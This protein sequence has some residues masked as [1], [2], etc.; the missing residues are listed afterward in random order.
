MLLLVSRLA[1]LCLTNAFSFVWK[2]E[3]DVHMSDTKYTVRSAGENHDKKSTGKH[4]CGNCDWSMMG[5]SRQLASAVGLQP[6]RNF[7]AR[8]RGII[9]RRKCYRQLSSSPPIGAV[10]KEC[11][12]SAGALLQLQET[13]ERD[14]EANDDDDATFSR[15]L[16]EYCAKP[17]HPASLRMLMKTGVGAEAFPG[18]PALQ[19]HHHSSAPP[20]ANNNKTTAMAEYLRTELP[21]RLAHRI[22]DLDQMPGMRDMDDVQQVQSIYRQSFR[23]LI[24]QFPSPIVTTQ[25]EQAFADRLSQLYQNH[26]SVL[27][28]MAKG[29]FQWRERI[30]EKR[31]IA[32]LRRHR[33]FGHSRNC[34]HQPAPIIV[35]DDD[36]DLSD[37]E[38]HNNHHS[39][40]DN[41]DD[42][43]II[44]DFETMQDCH[45]FLDRFY[46]SRIGIRFLAGQYLT[47]YSHHQKKKNNNN[48][49][50]VDPP[51]GDP[52]YI[53]LICLV[54]SPYAV[55]RQAAADA[56]QMCRRTYGRCPLVEI[57]GNCHL[58]FPYI[59]TYLHY[60]VLELLKNALRATME[61][62][63][64]DGILP[65]VK[66]IIADGSDNEDV[67]I[68]IADEGGGIRRSQMD[69]IWSYLYTTASPQIQQG[70]F[71]HNDQSDFSTQSPL[72]G[73]GYGLPIA[74]SYCRYFGGELDL[75]SMEG[76]G[77]DAFVHLKRFMGDD[78][79]T[80]PVPL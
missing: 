11:K 56:S 29:A 34:H 28:Q 18:Q 73:L 60:I 20:A 48:T 10:G 45:H 19:H 50:G 38:K 69:K 58:T 53:G 32:S 9:C 16:A 35:H 67:V 25:D 22:Q 51:T 66:V 47:L 15:V 61:T 41:D 13:A 42:D 74:R 27:V 72:A 76:Y 78:D 1:T 31:R 68:K 79:S 8:R 63:G 57:T 14:E 46:M 30:R 65:V 71:F 36:D 3:S 6:E 5:R 4:L 59:P 21:I 70:T 24:Y 23:E 54:T 64:G 39:N 77:T 55:V 43:T 49:I 7:L 62:H 2:D 33:G 75:L 37:D 80:E 44:P 17:P 40:D 52:N 26:S 12:E